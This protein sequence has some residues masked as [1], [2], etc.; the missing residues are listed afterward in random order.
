MLIYFLF[1]YYIPMEDKQH[2]PLV[3]KLRQEEMLAIEALVSISEQTKK[4]LKQE[5]L[6]LS[7]DV[8]IIRSLKLFWKET[9][10]QLFKELDV[11]KES[12]ETKSPFPWH[13][14]Y[15]AIWNKL[16]FL[17]K[18]DFQNKI[19]ITT[20]DKILFKDLNIMFSISEYNNNDF[21][22]SNISYKDH[23]FCTPW[24][25]FHCWNLKKILDS[26]PWKT[27][28]NKLDN[29]S[30]LFEYDYTN[31]YIAAHVSW[32]TDCYG[33]EYD[34]KLYLSTLDGHEECFRP[35]DTF[36]KMCC[37]GTKIV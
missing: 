2:N 12:P 35:S 5:L 21:K 7:D 34:D 17:K 18:K 33:D 13:Q 32:S 15:T 22:R 31:I 20:D 8:L 14:W 19:S 16:S 3:Q 10:K 26:I 37:I 9:K 29:F 11:Y 4:E 24:Y 28:K 27:K 25:M 6:S 36:K 30:V 1:S 23:C